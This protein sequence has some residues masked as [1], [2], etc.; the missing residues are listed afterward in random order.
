MKK[1][2]WSKNGSYFL[3]TCMIKH[4]LDAKTKQL[5]E[6]QWLWMM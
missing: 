4:C 5:S 3:L 1:E 2:Y 6:L